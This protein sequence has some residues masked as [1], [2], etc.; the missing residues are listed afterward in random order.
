DK[1]DAEAN[2]VMALLSY[3][4]ILVL[5]PIFAAKHSPFVRFHA[6][7]GVV[8]LLAMIGY[9]IADSIISAILRVVLYKGLGLWS[10][11]SMCNSLLSLLYVGFTIFAIIGIINVLN[12]RA[13]D[14]PIIGKYRVLK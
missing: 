7:Q 14:L 9:I 13:K 12:G 4:G 6:N 5:I 1:T 2:K 8:L 3:F 11:Y 10:I